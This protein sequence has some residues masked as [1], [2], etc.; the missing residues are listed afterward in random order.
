MFAS[1]KLK[2]I[3]QSCFQY[4]VVGF[5]SL[6]LFCIITNIWH[7]KISIP[8][9][10]N[11]DAILSGTLIKSVIDT[12]WYFTNSFI[13]APNGY[14]LADFPMADNLNFLI[15]KI[16]SYFIHHYAVLYN[17]FYILTFPTAA[18][19]A[20]FVYKRLGMI[21]PFAIVASILFAF[22]PYHFFK[23]EEGH[24]FLASYYV[25]PF[26]IWLAFS[27]VPS[28]LNSE[29][30]SLNTFSGLIINILLCL[31]IGSS[32]VYYA[33]F[34]MFFI[35][36]AGLGTTIQ[37][38]K[39]KP[40][41]K[42]FLLIMMITTTLVINIF[43]SIMYHEKF[44]A[45]TA[46]A[47][48]TPFEAEL[49]GLKISQML[50]PINND[51][52]S[53]LAE[54]KNTYN[55]TAPIVNTENSLTTLGLIASLGF[56]ILLAIILFVKNPNP[57]IEMIS[58][59]NLAAVLLATVGGLGSLFSY[60]LFPMIRCYSRISIF[61]AFFSLFGFFYFL[62]NLKLKLP[63]FKQEIL[64]WS[65]AFIILGIGIF[66]QTNQLF[67]NLQNLST[68]ANFNSDENFENKIEKNMN[69]GDLIF[70]LPFISFPEHS[71]VF[72]MVD[73]EQFRPYLHSHTLKWSYG[74]MKERNV[75]TWQ[76][77]L[78]TLSTVELLKNLSFS[79]YSGIYIDRNGYADH[80][81]VIEK[82]I[83]RITNTLPIV[84]DDQHFSFFN[85][86]S[87]NEKLKKEVN[88]NL[89]RENIK[90]NHQ[91]L[92]ISIGWA[93]G[94]YQ[95]ETQNN[96]SWHW[97]DK[98]GLLNL[99]N[100]G[101]N[102]IRVQV[103]LNLM[104]PDTNFSDVIIKNKSLYTK[105]RINN[106]GYEWTENIELS[107]GSNSLLFYSTANRALSPGDSRHLYFQVR[108]FSWKVI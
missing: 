84:S 43:P 14:N 2:K 77:Y 47:D 93:K 39:K 24:L 45:N 11:W 64:Q 105:M 57:E 99:V 106:K 30:T 65:L 80:G 32:G 10:Y 13:G 87:F 46:V 19:A 26:A 104:T 35:L 75:S 76:E 72:S 73:Y 28:S 33:V 20:L 101:T 53:S 6:L 27:I 9:F 85:I 71:P 34:A 17:V 18:I 97:C 61:I 70:Q 54:L 79:G 41:I 89:W 68:V 52:I 21:L 38:K 16:F 12:G 69:P 44:G 96:F 15:I 4:F 42:S 62:Q 63:I 90:I 58:K 81:L 91:Q 103:S 5:V 36:I 3:S 74:A 22:Q 108:N 83:T 55:D 40:L 29:I 92:D 60:T 67:A 48:R 49:Y 8:F 50:L 25:V 7:L 107:P 1:M 37:I 82:E 23:G 102:P 56:L 31:C 98:K 100:Y 95:L 78:S 94:F 51:R 59:L 66:T 88:N 86:H